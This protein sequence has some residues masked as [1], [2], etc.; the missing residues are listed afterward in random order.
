MSSVLSAQ[1][2]NTS[3]PNVSTRKMIKKSSL[4]DKEAYLREDALLEKKKFTR[5]LT[6]QKKKRRSKSVKTGFDR[7]F[8]NF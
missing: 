5:L 2:W 3:H 8:Q 7:K 6:I 4:E 1:H